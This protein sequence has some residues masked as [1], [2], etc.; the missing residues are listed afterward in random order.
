MYRTYVVCQQIKAE[1]GRGWRKGNCA[2]EAVKLVSILSMQLRIRKLGRGTLRD[3]LNL[4]ADGQG[5][6][7]I[8]REKAVLRI[9]IR[10]RIRIHFGQAKI[11]HKSEDNSSFYVPDVFFWGMKTSAGA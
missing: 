10:I 3:R 6:V 2:C 11:T 1:G 5:R 9:R 7:K 8:L 4:W